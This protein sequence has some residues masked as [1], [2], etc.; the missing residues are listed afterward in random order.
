MSLNGAVSAPVALVVEDE[1][2]VRMMAMDMLEE[3]GFA[4]LEA[5]T[6]DAALQILEGRADISLV[7]TDV[8]MPGS[9]NG[10]ALARHV[11]SRWPM[12]RVVVASGRCYATPGEIP[13]HVPFL[14]K[15]YYEAQLAD[16]IKGAA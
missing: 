8:E 10:F 15:P 16:A 7:F 3:A 6:A 11:A 1:D 5:A 2:L 12:I 4:V 13:P 14:R 9:M